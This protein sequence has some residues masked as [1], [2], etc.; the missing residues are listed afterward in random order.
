MAKAEAEGM[1]G[2][3]DPIID[4]AGI[5]YQFRPVFR[6]FRYRIDVLRPDG[7]DT[8]ETL[9]RPPREGSTC[10]I[11]LGRAL[12]EIPCR[13]LEASGPGVR[14]D[15]HRTWFG[16][17]ALVAPIRVLGGRRLRDRRF[18]HHPVRPVRRP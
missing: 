5:P 15:A 3:G 12:I 9:I 13:P 7:A 17:H 11:V 8:L 10:F 18:P 6:S 14:D 2:K 4:A 1:C 16:L